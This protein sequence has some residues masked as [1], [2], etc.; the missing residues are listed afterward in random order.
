MRLLVDT[1]VLLDILLHR[2][3]FY[4]EAQE[5]F[6]R[7]HKKRNEVIITAMSLRDIGYI[8]ARKTHSA[9]DGRR[10]IASA[11][12]LV[13]KVVG[14]MTDDAINA[15]FDRPGDYEDGLMMEAAKR[16]MADAII[17]RNEKDF[18]SSRIPVYSP[19]TINQIWES[20]R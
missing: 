6:L 20:Q 17:T 11:Y 12:R 5:F 7:C 9:E 2:E 18:G 15:L 3:G 16:S 8:V 10:A 1:N 4:E 13:T 19:K 14:V